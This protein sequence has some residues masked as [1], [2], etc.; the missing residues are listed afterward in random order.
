MATPSQDGKIF[1]SD[2][3]TFGFSNTFSIKPDFLRGAGMMA[4]PEVAEIVFVFRGSITGATGGA[5]GADAPR[6]F[7]R[8][9]FQDESEL[10][11]IT[12]VGLRVIEQMEFGSKQIDPTDIASAGSNTSYVALCRVSWDPVKALRPRDF[13][14]PLDHFLE[15]G[16][17]QITTP[18]QMPTGWTVNSGTI[19]AYFRVKDGRKRELKSRLRTRDIAVTNQEY[20]YDVGGLLRAAILTSNPAAATA[21]LTDL[22]AF[23]TFFSRSLETEPNLEVDVGTVDRY[24]R[25]SDSLSTRDEFTKANPG[26]VPYVTPDRWQK[27]GAM[28]D[29]RTFHLNLLAAPPTAASLITQVVEDRT[30]RL[31]AIVAGYSSSAD[32]MAAIARDGRVQDMSDGGSPVRQ[33]APSLARRLPIR[34]EPGK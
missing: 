30:P 34:I 33:W 17:L 6:L 2:P 8:I 29:L 10:C 14:V 9:R 15:G 27:I 21:G 31:A 23:N 1:R 19:R 16:Q 22:T 11:N 25:Q 12:G 24:R 5:L 32:L 4:A 7:G 26:A 20:D 3:Y 13:H 28:P 18:T